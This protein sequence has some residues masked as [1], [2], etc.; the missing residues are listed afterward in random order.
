[1]ECTRLHSNDG[2]LEFVSTDAK[3]PTPLLV[4]LSQHPSPK[5]SQPGETCGAAFLIPPSRTTVVTFTTGHLVSAKHHKRKRFTQRLETYLQPPPPLDK[6]SKPGKPS[7]RFSA[8]LD[9]QL[10]RTDTLN[11]RHH[12]EHKNQ[13]VERALVDSASIYLLLTPPLGLP[14]P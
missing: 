8:G 14:S 3:S 10:D 9:L 6:W 4:H 2:L 12:F 5:Q 1:M 11:G 13:R 7:P